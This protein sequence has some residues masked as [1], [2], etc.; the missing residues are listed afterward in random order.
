[1]MM[2]RNIYGV[3]SKYGFGRWSHVVYCFSDSALADKWLNKE[4]GS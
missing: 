3:S 2:K 4:D 1:M